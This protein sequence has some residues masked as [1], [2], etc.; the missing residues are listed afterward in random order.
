MIMEKVIIKNRLG[1]VLEQTKPDE[2]VINKNLLE[3]QGQSNGFETYKIKQPEP[4]K[5]D[6]YY[7]DG[8]NTG[9]DLYITRDRKLM[10]LVSL[11]IDSVE[12]IKEIAEETIKELIEKD[13]AG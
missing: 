6:W 3:I 7:Q 10:S 12:R 5:Y 13:N 9:Y 4:Y 8:W 2:I 11:Y 1:T